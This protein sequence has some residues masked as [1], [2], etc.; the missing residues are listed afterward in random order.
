MEKLKEITIKPIHRSVTNSSNEN[1]KY[2]MYVPNH[3]NE[4]I[5]FQ[6]KHPLFS[7]ICS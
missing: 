3:I 2:I 4:T 5:T 1:E 7:K 6:H